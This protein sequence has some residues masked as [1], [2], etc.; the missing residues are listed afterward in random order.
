[1]MPTE[2]IDKPILLDE[3]MEVIRQR[4]PSF[5]CVIVRDPGVAKN[6]PTIPVM[7]LK[8]VTVG[9]FLQFL[10]ASFPGVQYKR[11]DGPAGALYAIRVRMEDDPLRRQ[12]AIDRNR[13]R[14]FRLN[15]F[16]N[17]LADESPDKD[18]PREQKIKEATAQVLSLLQA[19]LEQTEDQEP[20]IVKIHEPT[21][22]LMF[23][24][25]PEKQAVLDEALSALMPGRSGSPRS[26]LGASGSHGPKWNFSLKDSDLDMNSFLRTAEMEDRAREIQ[27]EAQQLSRRMSE[28]QQQKQKPKSPPATQKT[29]PASKD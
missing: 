15:E 28:M 14:L 12:M 13:V 20:C 29:P 4:I 9:Q 16:I 21:L 8:N 11:I 10:Q 24:G 19:A 27:M 6:Y 26:G 23:K 18:K 5:N 25:S 7:M 1:M 17:T 22:T 2:R 3:Q